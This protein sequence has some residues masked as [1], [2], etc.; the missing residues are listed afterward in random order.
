M[1]K[2]QKE[3]RRERRKDEAGRRRRSFLKP[4]AASLKSAGAALAAAAAIAAGTSAYA[5]PVRYD[6]PAG[7]GHFDWASVDYAN[8]K[9]LDPTLDAASQPVGQEADTPASFWHHP[10]TY[11]GVFNGAGQFPNIIRDGYVLI[12]LNA[13]E[14]VAPTGSQYWDRYGFVEYY[15]GPFLPEGTPTYL[16]VRFDLGSGFQYGWIGVVRDAWVLDAFAWGYE[17]DPG[18]SIPAGAP[19]PGTLALLAMGAV[20]IAGRRRR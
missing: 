2:H 6:N 11:G 18:V 14:L 4:Q 19:E 8:A 15:G 20:A 10:D 16:G 17:T 3:L 7:P 5:D 12:G 9:W 1:S 13:G